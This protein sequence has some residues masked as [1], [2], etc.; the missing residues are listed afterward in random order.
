M[1]SFVTADGW[2]EIDPAAPFR[3][4]H[5]TTLRLRCDEFTTVLI[6]Q[7]DDQSIL[8]GQGQGELELRIKISGVVEFVTKGRVWHFA[9][10][11]AQTTKATSDE[12]FTTLDRP[13]PLSPE[14]AAIQRMMKQNEISRDHDREMMRQMIN[15][16]QRSNVRTNDKNDVVEDPA[17][18]TKSLRT[19]PER[20]ES[21]SGESK[22]KGD[23]PEADVSVST[24][25][26]GAD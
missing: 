3:I 26:K 5:E 1:K 10:V 19:K 4:T 12:I 20:G 11:A 16:S 8:A 15:A 13:S 14:M 23:Q 24:P 17:E 22:G 9:S 7:E 18:E 6:T 21:E 2:Q 25:K